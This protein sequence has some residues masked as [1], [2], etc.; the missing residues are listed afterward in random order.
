MGGLGSLTFR[1]VAALSVAAIAMV[2]MAPVAGV[3]PARGVTFSNAP[4]SDEAWNLV[5]ARSIALFGHAPR[6]E[7]Q[8]WLLTLPFTVVQ[9][10]AFSVFGVDLVVARLTVI[11]AV[12]TTGGLITYLLAP[13]VGL[14]NGWL[15]GV[16]AVTTALVLYYGRLAF[17]EPF[18]GAFLAVGVLT[19]GPATSRNPGRFGLV[20][21]VALA[22]SV[23]T[24]GHA[25]AAVAGVMTVAA[26]VAWATPWAR[27]WF[28]G[29][30]AGGLVTAIAWAMF[31][32]VPRRD[33]VLMVI[34]EIYPPYRWPADVG[35][36]IRNVTTY[37]GGDD[38]FA[39]AWPVL[40]LAAIAAVRLT[41]RHRAGHRRSG[42]VPAVAA[43]A[44]LLAGLVLLSI[45]DYNANRYAVAFV[46]LAAIASGW[47]LPHERS[48][49]S[50]GSAVFAA[51]ALVV[52]GHGLALHVGW[53]RDGGS[54]VTTIQQ[55]AASRLEPGSTV[56]GQYAPLV[57]L[58]LP[59][60][61]IVPFGDT[62]NEEDWY[63]SGARH[64][65]FPSDPSRPPPA[66]DAVWGA[67]REL[68]CFTWGRHAVRTCLYELGDP[69][70]PPSP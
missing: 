47:A 16:A 57:A 51:A 62:I 41:L 26:A 7:W 30:M 68:G 24:K 54:E 55:L 9:A 36:L 2:L 25:V 6:D 69:P 32:L 52:V 50:R 10:L 12:A 67:R 11:L 3:D 46:P 63:Q 13:L 23:M 27:R 48:L 43:L 59:V 42:D 61:V 22:M 44:G 15:A 60:R 28:A 18:V 37:P 34:R 53:L 64:V 4:F 58:E 38:T 8:T 14:R 19:L 31:V 66:P 65:V 29:A 33:D 5:G 56:V 70:P 1:A 45:P 49:T 39:L 20:G 35:E 17:L 21:G 40:G